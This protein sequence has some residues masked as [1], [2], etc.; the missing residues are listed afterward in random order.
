MFLDCDLNYGSHFRLNFCCLM[1]LL[2]YLGVR[3]ETVP[4]AGAGAG[5]EAEVGADKN[6]CMNTVLVLAVFWLRHGTCGFLE[7]EPELFQL[8]P[9]TRLTQLF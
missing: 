9:K 1:T 3:A 8:Q 7:K 5:A 6:T 2:I 4:R